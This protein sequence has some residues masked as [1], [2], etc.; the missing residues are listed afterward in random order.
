MLLNPHTPT[1]RAQ[2]LQ[3]FGHAW[4]NPALRDIDAGRAALMDGS[5]ADYRQLVRSFQE[6]DANVA[7]LVARVHG[8]EL[9]ADGD[10]GPATAAVMQYKRCSLPDFAPPPG[11]SFDYGDPELNAAVESYQ[12]YAAAGYVGGSG[13]WP[14]GCDPTQKDVHSVVVAIDTSNASAHQKGIMAEVLKYVEQT[15]AEMGQAVRHVL[16]SSFSRPQHD[17]KFQ[18]IAGGVIGFAYFPDPDT[19]NQTVTARIDNSFDAR[20]FVLAEL[21]THEYK[22]HSDGLEHTRGGIMNPSIGSPTARSS[23][24]GDPHEKTKTRYFGGVALPG[25]IPG[26]TPGPGPN[27]VP[28]DPW[29]GGSIIVNRPGEPPRRFIPALDV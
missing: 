24:K 10:V 12:R 11:A 23:W 6:L 16:D 9:S 5:E 26:P 14:K 29:F 20:A 21:L 18:F 1:E 22:G 4:G 8:R 19:C 25:P 15:E 28:G 27:P 13:S 17:V 2:W 3:Q 7:D